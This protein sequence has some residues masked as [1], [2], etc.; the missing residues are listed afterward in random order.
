MDFEICK[1]KG[2]LVV[3]SK[4]FVYTN[5]EKVNAL[6]D[7]LDRDSRLNVHYDERRATAIPKRKFSGLRISPQKK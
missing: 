4:K 3:I 2:H 6:A 1:S 5:D 7:C